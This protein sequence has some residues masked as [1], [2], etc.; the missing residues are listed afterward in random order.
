MCLSR[1]ADRKV[2]ESNT[3]QEVTKHRNDRTQRLYDSEAH[4]V[5]S[6]IF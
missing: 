2:A 5:N 3:G 6:G 1:A 4:G